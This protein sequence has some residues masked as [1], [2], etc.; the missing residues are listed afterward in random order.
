MY[1]NH[2]LLSNINHLQQIHTYVCM[3]VW[4]ENKY[5]FILISVSVLYWKEEVFFYLNTTQR[6]TFNVQRTT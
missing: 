6:T 3:Y 1:V 2:L 5:F 4:E